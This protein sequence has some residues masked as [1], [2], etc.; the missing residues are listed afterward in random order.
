MV[1]DMGNSGSIYVVVLATVILFLFSFAFLVNA[2]T[3]NEKDYIITNFGIKNGN[4]YIT[5][6]GA[7]GGSY[8]PSMGDEGYQAYVFDTDKGIFQVTVAE[9]SSSKPYYSTDQILVKDM[10]LNECLL[11]K[12]TQGK[13]LFD[14]NMVEFV[15]HKLDITKV[16]RAFAIQVTSDDP[17][18]KCETGEHVRK[19]YP[20][21]TSQA[22]QTNATMTQ[23]NAT[24]TTEVENNTVIDGTPGAV[25]ID[26]SNGE[27]RCN[28]A[29]QKGKINGLY[30][31]AYNRHGTVTGHWTLVNAKLD[32]EDTSG[33][34]SSGSVSTTSYSL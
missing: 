2:S 7:A 10:K 32:G 14:N 8:D 15:D 23:T 21:Q 26:T 6:E 5:V 27:Y 31:D 17:D 20:S 28:G 29:P 4:P 11:T 12:E 3:L 24:T 19:I 16:N 18:E 13:P 1:N 9:G 30:V 25:D 33:K 34:I 22:S